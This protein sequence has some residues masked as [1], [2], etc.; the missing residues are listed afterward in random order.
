MRFRAD[1]SYEISSG[2]DRRAF[3]EESNAHFQEIIDVMKSGDM[4]V[5]DDY[6]E[7]FEM[8]AQ[9]TGY[10][11]KKE[12][13]YAALASRYKYSRILSTKIAPL[14][15]NGLDEASNALVEVLGEVFAQRKFNEAVNIEVVDRMG[16]LRAPQDK[17][18]DQMIVE[19][20]VLVTRADFIASGRIIVS[21]IQR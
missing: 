15:F 19:P 16:F 7:F 5:L 10:Y 18:K 2:K 17:Q 14:E 9:K 8:V 4:T 12:G 1:K 20:L 21:A 13:Y 3:L 6:K 11:H